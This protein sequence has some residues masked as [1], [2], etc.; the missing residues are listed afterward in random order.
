MPSPFEL[1]LRPLVDHPN[2]NLSTEIKDWL[3]LSEKTVR[4]GVARELIALANHDGGYLLFGFSETDGGWLPSPHD[5]VELAH[6]SQDA[7]NNI[8]KAH[9]VPVFECHTAHIASSGGTFHV[10]VR[11]PGGHVVPI[12]SHGGPAGSR[13][14]DHTYY[15]RRPGPESAPP[16]NAGEWDALISRCV[17]NNRERQLEGFRRI[18]DA[19]RTSPEIV[20][21]LAE[22]TRGTDPLSDWIRQSRERLPRPEAE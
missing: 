14:T 1:E 20:S 15:V 12:R 2:E 13:L 18:I 4:A 9:A 6:Y 7:I 5:G 3:D 11:V 17:A 10:V 19:M 22:L 16:D 8:L 21:E